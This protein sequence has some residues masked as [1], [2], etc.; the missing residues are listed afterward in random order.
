MPYLRRATAQKLI[1][2]SSALTPNPLSI[3]PSQ[4]WYGNDG[5]WNPFYIGFGAPA[6][7]VKL[8]ISTTATLPNAVIPQACNSSLPATCP[9]NRGGLFDKNQSSTWKDDGFFSLSI[10]QN[11]GSKATGNF[12][13]DTVQLGLPGSQASNVTLQGQLVAGIVSMNFYLA[14]WGL[15]PHD[16]N[17]TS[18]NNQYPSVIQ[19]LKNQSRIPSKSWGYT[20]GAYHRSQVSKSAFASL[21]LGGSDSSR[22][23]PHN[24]TFNFAADVARDLI[25]GIQSITTNTTSNSLLKEPVQAFLDSGV[26]HIWLPKSAC[27]SFQAAFN[28]TY[29]STIG[30]YLVNDTV[31]DALIK[32]NPN[33][34]FT[35]SN[36]LVTKTP[37][38]NISLPY[39]AFDLNL[40]T[41]YPGILAN[42]TRY[43]PLRQAANDSQ[44]TLGRTFFQE[45]Y[46]IADYERSKFSV[47]QTLF[48]DNTH[49]SV[50]AISPLPG[51]SPSP[52]SP[53][54]SS[55]SLS[56][57]AIV[58]ISVVTTLVAVALLSLGFQTRKRWLARIGKRVQSE[59]EISKDH[60]RV[61][62][63]HQD[64]LTPTCEVS[65]IARRPSEL[66]VYERA[67]EFDGRAQVHEV[68]GTDAA[69]ELGSR[70]IYEL[71]GSDVAT[72]SSETAT[73]ASTEDIETTAQELTEVDITDYAQQQIE[74]S[75]F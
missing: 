53:P 60:I 37:T 59:K 7:Y 26:P 27:D 68:R 56:T 71:P 31:H 3:V 72:I 18:M 42:N 52:D 44:Y 34:T 38:I 48:P 39:A 30:L 55:P 64:S 75:M 24:T 57:G 21:I 58:A 23:V 4:N 6:Q 11:L 19:N 40:T 13:W 74:R 16:T 69:E 12:G 10:E 49:Q 62:E 25:V 63:L 29:N 46:V 5:P 15:R 17:L 70:S 54:A 43:F 51:T 32:Q 45:A 50:Q 41:D 47:H 8:L 66:V 20:A 9:A 67:A 35:L 28:L 33:V 65:G 14:N 22:Y 1:T 2:K 61:P 73:S 36:D